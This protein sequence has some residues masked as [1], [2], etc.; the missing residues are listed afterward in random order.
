[1]ARA[2]V[3]PVAGARAG[4]SGCGG[5]GVLESAKENGCRPA[6][7]S[8][9]MAMKMHAPCGFKGDESCLLAFHV[10]RPWAGRGQNIASRPPQ[11]D[12]IAII[13]KRPS[14]LIR[15]ATELKIAS[16]GGGGARWMSH[17]A[18]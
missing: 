7:W 15:K 1:M 4:L 3:R 12:A 14:G 10:F 11:R 5:Q 8:A 6:V 18:G 16:N 13:S 2:V 9:R 17:W